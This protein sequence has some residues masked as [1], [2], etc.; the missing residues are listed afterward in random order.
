MSI[1]SE[2][3]AIW[4]TMIKHCVLFGTAL[5]SKQIWII[6]QIIWMSSDLNLF[7]LELR[8]YVQELLRIL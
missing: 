1:N 7:I 5:I 4:N 3:K 6:N 8:I 2:R